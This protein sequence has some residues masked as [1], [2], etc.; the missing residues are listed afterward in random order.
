[1]HTNFE[2]IRDEIEYLLVRNEKQ[3]QTNSKPNQKQS[4]YQFNLIIINKTELNQNE[5]INKNEFI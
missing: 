1:M 4:E 3:T 2:T 5:G